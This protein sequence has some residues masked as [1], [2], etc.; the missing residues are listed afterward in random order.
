MK[1]QRIV[2]LLIVISFLGSCAT[3]DRVLFSSSRNGNSDI[4]LMDSEGKNLQQITEEQT[5]E[6][7]PVWINENEISYLSQNGETITLIR[8]NLE[9]GAKTTIDHPSNCMLDDKNLVYSKNAERLLYPCKGEIYLLDQKTGSTQN[10]T[11]KME[12][13]A[14]YPAWG[15]NDQQVTFTSNHEGNNEVYLLNTKTAELKNLT[16]NPANDERGDI[17]KNGKYLVFSSDRFNKG[18]QDLVIWNL[19]KGEQ[20]AEIKSIGMQLIA[21]WSPREKAIY[22]GSN[23]EGYWEIYSYHLKEKRTLRMTNSQ[24]FDGDPRA[25]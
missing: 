17:S 20:V 18:D 25:K 3:T 12:G 19:K 11:E 22:Y 13:V 24:S 7:G 6:W 5:E 4:F 21:R 1:I 14:N 9:T 15:K 10:L 2:S 8:H 23:K 16:N